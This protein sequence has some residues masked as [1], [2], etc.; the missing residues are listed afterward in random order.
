MTLYKLNDSYLLKHSG[1]GS[2]IIE[3][4]G[5]RFLDF[6]E[7]WLAEKPNTIV[8]ISKGRRIKEYGS[9]SAEEY[10]KALEGIT[11]EKKDCG[12]NPIF[13]PEERYAYDKFHEAYPPTYEDY[14][15]QSIPAIVEYDITGNLSNEYIVPLRLIGQ[16]P[17]KDNNVMY[18]YYPNIYK[19]A[20]EVAKQFGFEEVEDTFRD[21]TKGMKWSVPNHSKD[22]LEYMK[23]NTHY[24]KHKVARNGLM[25]GTYDECLS[26]YQAQIESISDI[27][28]HEKDMMN[29]VGVPVD[30]ETVVKKL[31]N[32]KHR[33]A[34]INTKRSSEE[35]PHSIC[36]S[37]TE[38]I[39]DILK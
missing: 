4:D 33:V 12:G 31:E 24:A 26:A 38:L 17:V 29:A 34:K 37:I 3:V 11:P 39:N 19:M 25:Y 7:G 10:E 14:E 2:N 22:T 35:Q 27:F 8:L 20:Q 1:Y 13:T 23:L 30:K 5:K 18:R 15:E 21:N 32:L 9:L 36:A 28:Q 6:K 16:E